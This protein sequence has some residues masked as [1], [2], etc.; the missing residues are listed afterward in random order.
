[1]RSLKRLT[2]PLDNKLVWAT[3]NAS[4]L[5]HAGLLGLIAV[6]QNHTKM[7]FSL[8]E[9]D[10]SLLDAREETVEGLEQFPFLGCRGRDQDISALQKVDGILVSLDGR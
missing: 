2:F 7:P 10:P 5:G 4:F 9:K 8:G 3:Q 6:Q 1:M